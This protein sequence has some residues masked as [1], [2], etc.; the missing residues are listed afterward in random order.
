LNYDTVGLADELQVERIKR[1][2]EQIVEGIGQGNL[3]HAFAAFDEFLNGDF[4][5]HPTYFFNI[6]GS[7]EYFNLLNPVYPP[8]PYPNFLTLQ[9]IF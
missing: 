4:Y 8:N 9:S 7:G 5:P 6:T 1:Y 2:E 3:V